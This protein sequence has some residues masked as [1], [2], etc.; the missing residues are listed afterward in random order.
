MNEHLPLLQSSSNMAA[1]VSML[2][3]AHSLM[4]WIVLIAVGT[5][6]SIALRGWLMQLPIIVWQ[7]SLAIIALAACHLQ[8]VLGVILYGIRFKRYIAP[9]FTPREIV[10]WKYEHIAV[11]LLAVILVTVGRVLSKRA[12]TEPAKWKMI[13][14]FY[15]VAFALMCWAIPWPHTQFGM[16]RSWL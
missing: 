9:G 7:R 10:F 1:S 15:L 16:E 3:F 12:K 8:V 5:A 6:G 14:I 2:F 13:A 4:R 11:M